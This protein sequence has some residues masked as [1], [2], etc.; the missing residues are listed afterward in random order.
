MR[1]VAIPND[2]TRRL[3]LSAADWQLPSLAVVADLLSSMPGAGRR[4]TTWRTTG[5][6]LARNVPIP[7]T[8]P[9]N[10]FDY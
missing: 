3:D 2:Q 7:K 4:V 10:G 8:E 5:L 1:A 9:D 6:M